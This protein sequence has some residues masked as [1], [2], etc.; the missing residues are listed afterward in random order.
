[1]PLSAASEHDGAHPTPRTRARR[2][3]L[4]PAT[5]ALGAV[6]GATATIWLHVDHNRS[7]RELVGGGLVAVLALTATLG[8]RLGEQRRWRRLVEES[9]HPAAASVPG[10]LAAQAEAARQFVGADAAAIVWSDGPDT[11]SVGALAGSAPPRLRVGAAL[12]PT[13]VIPPARRSRWTPAHELPVGDPCRV[14]GTSV[15]ARPL[16]A[17]G[18]VAGTIVMWSAPPDGRGAPATLPGGAAGA[19]RIERARLDDAERRSRLGASH[20]RRHLAMLVAAS[21]TLARAIDD[22]QPAFEA[23]AS[24]IVPLHADYFAVDLIRDDGGLERVVGRA[25]RPRKDRAVPQARARLA[26]V[27]RRDA[28]RLGQSHVLL[29][30]DRPGGVQITDATRPGDGISALHRSLELESWAIVPIRVR[31]DIVGAISVGT[32]AHR[33]GLRPSDVETYEELA[34]RSAL[35][36][37]RVRLYTASESAARVAEANA[38]RL[39][40]AVEAAP[41]LASSL[42]VADILQRTARQAFRTMD[43]RLAAVQLT[44]RGAAPRHRR[45]GPPSPRSRRAPASCSAAPPPRG[46]GR[47]CRSCCRAAP[48]RACSS[49]TDPRARTSAARSS[50]SSAC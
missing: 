48:P 42:N 23:L 19:A 15:M 26:G 34:S 45:G 9:D 39:V 8:T 36:I 10:S 25:R 12:G 17:G 6:I 49:S 13:A 47:P 5:A 18:E 14:D 41:T 33:R 16:A 30:H 46:P 20:A 27:A 29:F 35:T 22:W 32:L 7:A 24:E 11:I 38:A 1:M 50:P 40:R 44:R 3:W 4:L 31:T 21:A 2:R 28:R 43:A 37:E